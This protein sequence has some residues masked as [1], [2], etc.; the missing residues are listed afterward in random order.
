MGVSFCL[1]AWSDFQVGI[2]CYLEGAPCLGLYIYAGATSFWNWRVGVVRLASQLGFGNLGSG[3]LPCGTRWIHT[4]STAVAFLV[5][6]EDTRLDIRRTVALVV[7]SLLL[8]YTEKVWYW[9]GGEGGGEVVMCGPLT[10]R[11]G[12][13]A[14]DTWDGWLTLDPR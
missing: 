11:I 7:F 2:Q 10:E 9:V 14:S 6:T 3:R 5:S 4:L 13:N 1:G 12:S 8:L